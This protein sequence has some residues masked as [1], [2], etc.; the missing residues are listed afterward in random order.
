MTDSLMD[1][2]VVSQVAQ[3][4]GVEVD[5][6]DLEIAITVREGETSSVR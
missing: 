5:D 2:F 4:A 1:A 3:A 6:E